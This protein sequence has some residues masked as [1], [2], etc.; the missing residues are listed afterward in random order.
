MTSMF[1]KEMRH[2]VEFIPDRLYYVALS[3]PPPTAHASRHFFSVD[4]EMVYWNFYLDFGPLNLG[5]LYRFCMLLN[6]KLNDS[7]L[8]DKAIFFYSHTH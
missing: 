3:S 1:D 6:N 7:R 2:A 5:H 4:K 8:K